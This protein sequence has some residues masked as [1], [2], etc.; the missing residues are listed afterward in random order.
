[1]RG[2]SPP[3]PPNIEQ[4]GGDFWEM[5]AS[6]FHFLRNHLCC[7]VSS[8]IILRLASLGLRIIGEA[9][10]CAPRTP[11]QCGNVWLRHMEKQVFHL[12][13]GHFQAKLIDLIKIVVK[14][15]DLVL[16]N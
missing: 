3:E 2:A 12:I 10:S 6:P 15:E 14:I 13:N 16:F 4:C 1:M 9:G 7:D 8:P 11:G 5:G